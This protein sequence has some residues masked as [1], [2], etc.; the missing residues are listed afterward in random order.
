M[1]YFYSLSFE[2]ASLYFYGVF[3]FKWNKQNATKHTIHAETTKNPEYT[4]GSSKDDPFSITALKDI[5]GFVNGRSRL[6]H[7]STFGIP[8]M[9]QM[10]PV[11]FW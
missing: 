10:N 3:D 7:R 1:W 4:S 2:V 11:T 8:S 5:P 6:I 9:G